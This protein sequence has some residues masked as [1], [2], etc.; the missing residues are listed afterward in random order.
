L[1]D[2]DD[3]CVRETRKLKPQSLSASTSANLQRSQRLHRFSRPASFARHHDSLKS[4][5]VSLNNLPE[6]P[7]STKA[8]EGAVDLPRL[9]RSGTKWQPLRSRPVPRFRQN[10]I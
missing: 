5:K 8:R 4:A 6:T 7:R 2:L 9:Y 10:P 1:I 3:G